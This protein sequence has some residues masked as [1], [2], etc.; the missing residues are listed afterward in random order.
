MNSIV[1]LN[2]FLRRNILIICDDL[3][4]VVRTLALTHWCRSLDLVAECPLIAI[5]ANGM[6]CLDI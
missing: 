6:Y 4:Q 2:L 5:G 3:F 1:Y